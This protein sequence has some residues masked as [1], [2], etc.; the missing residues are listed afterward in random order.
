MVSLRHNELGNNKNKQMKIIVVIIGG[1]ILIAIGVKAICVVLS[2]KNR[3]DRARDRA[4]VEHEEQGW[5]HTPE[6]GMR[7]NGN[8]PAFF[9]SGKWFAEPTRSE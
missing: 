1:G 5:E 2:L 7:A 4:A 8:G 6:P 9:Y 3:I